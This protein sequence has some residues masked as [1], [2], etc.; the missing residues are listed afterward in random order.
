MREEHPLFEEKPDVSAADYADLTAQVKRIAETMR[1]LDPVAHFTITARLDLIR[2]SPDDGSALF[3]LSAGDQQI[4]AL[5][6]PLR[7]Q[8]RLRNIFDVTFGGMERATQ[9]ERYEKLRAT[10]PDTVNHFYHARWLEETG[11]ASLSR[12][13]MEYAV[14]SLEELRLLELTLYFQ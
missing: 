7:A 2:R 9:R 12:H 3:L 8:T 10:Y 14:I 1:E 5:E 11:G 4:R 6:E 13:R